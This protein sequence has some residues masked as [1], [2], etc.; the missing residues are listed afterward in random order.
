MTTQQI[1][2]ATLTSLKDKVVAGDEDAARVLADALEEAGGSLALRSHCATLVFVGESCRTEFAL[3]SPELGAIR[4][5]GFAQRWNPETRA[6]ATKAY[7]KSFAVG[8]DAEFDSYK[9][10]YTGPIRSISVK[11]VV[12]ETGRGTTRT[13]KPRAKSLTLREFNSRN[14]DHD[15]ERVATEN[16]ERMNYL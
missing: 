1:D 12:I 5:F 4:L 7:S 13:G 15:A 16:A 2:D 14:W 11:R 6:Y 9:L 8:D 3:V 10:S